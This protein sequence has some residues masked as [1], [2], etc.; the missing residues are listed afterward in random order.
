MKCRW[1][2]EKMDGVRGFWNGNNMLS[3]NGKDLDCP[4]WF[5]HRF[6]TDLPTGMMLDG[7]LWMGPGT[8]HETVMSVLSSIN[9]DWSQLGYY[10][11]DIPSES[12]RTYEE[13]MEVMNCI[14]PCLPTHAHIVNNIRCNGKEHL[15]EYL[16]S[17]LATR[18]E[19]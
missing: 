16:Q 3:R 15:L 17:I 13:R 19:G 6:I 9:S 10:I 1:M 7:E 18:G 4:S 5:V 2:S 14:K 12:G 11:Y 8:S